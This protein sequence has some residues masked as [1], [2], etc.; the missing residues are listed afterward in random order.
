MSYLRITICLFLVAATSTLCAQESPLDAAIKM[1]RDS[2][3]PRQLAT[4]LYASAEQH[5]MAERLDLA[6][7]R[8]DESIDISIKSDDAETLESSLMTAGK[9][10][11]RL[12]GEAPQ[13]FYVAVLKRAEESPKMRLAI[14]KSLGRQLL[15][16][17]DVVTSIVAMHE[18]Y[19]LISE[20]SPE[21][22]EAFW[23]TFQY[24]QACVKGK[25][26]DIGLPAMKH[27]R[28]I[29]VKLGRLDLASYTDLPIGNACLITK[30]FDTGETIF[31]NQ[32]DTAVRSKDPDAIAQAVYGLVSLWLRVQK[33]DEA[34]QL[35]LQSIKAN[36]APDRAAMRGMLQSQLALLN[37]ARG[38]HAQAADVATKGIESKGS[39]IPTLMRGSLIAQ[40]T[41]IDQLALASFHHLAGNRNASDA[42]LAQCVRGYQFTVSQAEQLARQGLVSLDAMLTAYSEVPASVSALKQQVL[43]SDNQSDQALVES[44]RGR[45][46]AQLE[47]MRRHF[48]LEELP[49]GSDPSLAQIREL[50]KNE[51][52]TL[53]EYSVI[54]PLDYYSREMLGEQ[55]GL[56]ASSELYIWVVS[57]DGSIAFERVK[58]PAD[59]AALVEAA[60]LIVYPPRK[61]EAPENDDST[62]ET[63]ESTEARQVRA[64]EPAGGDGDALAALSKMLIAPIE[65]HL[66]GSPDQELVIVPHR[67]LFAIP[68]AALP[69]ADG[70]PLVAKHTLVHA[71]SI[72]AYAMSATRRGTATQFKFD[73]I[74][75]VGN[76][77]MPLYRYRPDQPAKPLTPLPG[78]EREAKAIGQML[79]IQ[80]LIG[81]QANES[82][83]RSQM[84]IAP[85]IHLAS[86][87]VLEADNALSQN[88]LSSIALSPD[89]KNNGFLTVRE[90]MQM[91]LGADM[92]VLSACDSGR[93]KI[94][95][96][97]VV[98][99]SRGYLAAGVPTV[100][101][102]LW[103][104]SDQATAY[105][106]VHFYEALRNGASKAVALRKAMLTTRQQFEQP[107]LWAPFTIYGVG[108]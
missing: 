101:V 7:K 46:Q 24:G 41:M 77:E 60:R 64:S 107:R 43:V 53:V 63:D 29:A 6:A 92:A 48:G 10:L 87:G 98:G 50:A 66:P 52:A 8:I 59:V 93:G 89:D 74:L 9:I 19:E 96:D 11:T 36:A 14:L 108:H 97:G 42:A 103:P 69:M 76:P 70:E 4:M 40:T 88:Y 78:A 20:S 95:G 32:L 67:E 21:S 16:S 81:A 83:V 54:H 23:V 22:E 90:I 33:F 82:A 99:L 55:S 2:A 105:L 73:D 25:L 62:D 18:A 17:G 61:K 28:S 71:A 3:E 49:A 86:H 30:E 104:V 68:F 56:Y 51:N 1:V 37:A 34:E 94:T 44:E 85:V 91:N 13:E 27:A 65:K 31:R 106:M 26:F 5:L 12:R 57:P 75:I 84:M 15:Q 80:P 100:V 35:L 102:S 45:G 79:G 47:S 38:N 58:L 39:A 72:G